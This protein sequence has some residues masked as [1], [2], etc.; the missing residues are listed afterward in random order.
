M[1]LLSSLP[2]FLDL[3][4]RIPLSHRLKFSIL[5]NIF[6]DCDSDFD[7]SPSVDHVEGFEVSDEDFPQVWSTGEDFI[8][9]PLPNTIQEQI[10]P[11]GF[12]VG[13][14]LM[15]LCSTFT[16]QVIKTNRLQ[17]NQIE[18]FLFGAGNPFFS[19]FDA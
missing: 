9:S 18:K 7:W 11:V 3:V 5:F 8:P 4:V 15:E 19:S 14:L 10:E 13:V 16:F 17:S 6:L 1:I 12:Q 2:R